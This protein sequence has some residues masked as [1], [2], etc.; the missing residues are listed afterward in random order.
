MSA[1]LREDKRRARRYSTGSTISRY[2]GPLPGS[3]HDFC[4]YKN[5]KK[6][7]QPGIRSVISHGRIEMKQPSGGRGSEEQI[8]LIGIIKEEHKANKMNSATETRKKANSSRQHKSTMQRIPPSSQGSMKP[9]GTNTL[10]RVPSE[11]RG[12][13]AKVKPIVS[14]GTRKSTGCSIHSLAPP[15]ARKTNKEEQSKGD[16]RAEVQG[17][18]LY[19]NDGKVENAASESTN[20]YSSCSFYDFAEL[21]EVNATGKE[22]EAKVNQSIEDACRAEK[23]NFKREKVNGLKPL[24][25][26]PRWLKFRRPSDEDKNEDCGYLSDPGCMKVDLRHWQL[27]EKEATRLLNDIIEETAAEL[28]R[29][30]KSK[31]KALVGAFETVISLQDVDPSSNM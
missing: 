6:E 1:E 12:L 27:Q 16:N 11:S 18:E 21:D 30:Q 28:S 13:P 14:N 24:I 31:V 29:T 22:D 5:G 19:S 26:S 10:L 23:L 8:T 4:K 3:C 9:K 7:A 17:E 15:E 2:L 25:H 20:Y